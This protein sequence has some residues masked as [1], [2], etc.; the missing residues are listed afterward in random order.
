MS[1]YKVEL[2]LKAELHEGLAVHECK[3]AIRD[4]SRDCCQ[5]SI[6]KLDVQLGR[7]VLRFLNSFTRAAACLFHRIGEAKRA[8]R[9]R[10]SDPRSLCKLGNRDHACIT[11]PCTCLSIWC[12]VSYVL[13]DRIG[14][15]RHSI[16]FAVCLHNA[17]ICCPKQQVP[18]NTHES[19]PATYF[20]LNC[21][22]TRCR[23][24][25]RI[26]IATEAVAPHLFTLNCRRDNASAPIWN[27]PSLFALVA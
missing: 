21:W 15:K 6:E 20:H 3:A 12:G 4:S 11:I 13:L 18:F 9:G 16:N 24:T 14:R 26:A 2:Q 1:S 10:T 22:Q 19:A 27:K 23:K 25:S 7:S 17:T 5:K 8:E